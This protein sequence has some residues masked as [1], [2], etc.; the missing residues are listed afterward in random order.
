[1]VYFICDRLS[2]QAWYPGLTAISRNQGNSVQWRR[3]LCAIIRAEG[4]T[5]LGRA[6]DSIIGARIAYALGGGGARGLA[7]IG[8]IKVLEERGIRPGLIAGTSMGALVGALY[9]SGLRASDIERAACLNVRRLALLADFRPSA[10]GLVQG[11]R[12][13]ELLK[14]FLGDLTFE[15][16]K[17]PFVCVA[18]DI[19]NG[20]EVILRS[21]QV[22]T[23]V[24]ASISIPGIFTPVSVRGRYL[25][26]GGLV[27]VVPV[28][29]CRDLAAGY[30]VG[31]N[32]APH[33]SWLE[34]EMQQRAGDPG[35]GPRRGR[36]SPRRPGRPAAPSMI[37]VLL[38]SVIIPG[39]RIAQENLKGADLVISPEMGDIGFFQF[40]RAAE[41][42]AAGE[43][44]AR[45]ALEEADLEG[46]DHG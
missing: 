32:V 43:E 7:H 44:A 39:Y 20:Q 26:D 10:S 6:A 14:S 19:L 11:K 30:V 3:D 29:T 36:A 46:Q 25:V 13:T 31:V 16:L 8:V 45:R 17:I 1:M 28:Q 15:G 41:A 24:R 18:A 2:S 40:D 33:P 9:A 35:Q 4:E 34:H 12:V 5:P 22:T 42:I 38:Q 27:N 37:K 21:G 23:A